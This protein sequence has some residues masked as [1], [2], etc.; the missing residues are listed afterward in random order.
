G[1]AK[2]CARA[3]GGDADHQ[4]ALEAHDAAGGGAKFQSFGVGLGRPGGLWR[5]CSGVSHGSTPH[6]SVRALTAFRLG[7]PSVRLMRTTCWGLAPSRSSA[8][9]KSRS[10]M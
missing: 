5:V 1:D 10:T 3:E 9:A 2:E 8:A 6:R 4:A 7:T